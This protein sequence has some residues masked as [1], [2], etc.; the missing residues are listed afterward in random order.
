LAPIQQLLHNAEFVLLDMSL[1]HIQQP[2]TATS[3][4]FIASEGDTYPIENGNIDSR[5][6]SDNELSY[7]LGSYSDGANDM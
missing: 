4:S 3:S 5:P 6:L 1:N 7:Y 2:V